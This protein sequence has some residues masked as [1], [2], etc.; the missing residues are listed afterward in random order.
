M[1][2][3]NFEDIFSSSRKIERKI[4]VEYI[5]V[6][7]HAIT[8]TGISNDH[9]SGHHWVLVQRCS[10]KIV[11]IHHASDHNFD[12]PYYPSPIILRVDGM[13]SNELPA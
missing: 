6:T 12:S 5:G 8:A 13:D 11:G 1:N 3:Y 4:N 2:V 7:G 9:H 10:D